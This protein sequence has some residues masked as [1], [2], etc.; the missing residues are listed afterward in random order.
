M[1][2]RLMTKPAAAVAADY[3][4]SIRTVRKWQQCYAA[5]GVEALADA[6][7]RTKRCRCNLTNADMNRIHDLRRS[8]KSGDE[9]AL[10]LGLCRCTVFRALRK[11]GL[12]RLSSLEPKPVLRRYEWDS[13]GDMLHVDIKRLGKIDGIGHRKAGTRQAKRKRLGW[14]YLHVCV[15]DASRLAYTGIH[16]DETAESAVEFL[17]YAVAWY[18]QYGI[19]VKRVLTDNG[20]CYTSQKFRQACREFGLQH[21][22]TKPYHPQTNGKADG[23]S[24]RP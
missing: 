19:Q 20:A 8:R 17:W 2:R 12:S 16:A 7:S 22:R 9:I 3:G 14:E 15:D 13:P 23:S 5:G 21:K 18:K 1:V 6:S 4:L 11:L 24:E 10:H